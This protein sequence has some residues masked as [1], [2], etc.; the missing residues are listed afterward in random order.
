MILREISPQAAPTSAP[1]V[2]FSDFLQGEYADAQD[3]ILYDVP[4]GDASSSDIIMRELQDI[5]ATEASI[6]LR[7]RRPCSASAG[8]STSEAVVVD[9]LV[10]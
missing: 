5:S 4:T 1:R 8:V 2:K 10:R 6:V 7:S 9:K 3:V